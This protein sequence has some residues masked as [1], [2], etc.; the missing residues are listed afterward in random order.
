MDI[1]KLEALSARL[2]DTEGR[3]TMLLA[4]RLRATIAANWSSGSPSGAGE[5]P[6]VVSG[7]LASSI[8]TEAGESGEVRVGTDLAYGRALEYGTSRMAAR[9]WLRPA[10]EGVRAEVAGLVREALTSQGGEEDAGTQTGDSG[11]THQ[12]GGERDGDL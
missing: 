3:I 11:S 10:V 12:R 4:E 2:A 1:S 5:P 9:P 8:R 6:A 7:G